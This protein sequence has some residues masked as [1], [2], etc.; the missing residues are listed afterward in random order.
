MTSPRLFFDYRGSIFE[1]SSP[2]VVDTPLEC[3]KKQG[4]KTRSCFLTRFMR[5]CPRIVYPLPFI[6]NHNF[7]RYGTKGCV[8]KA[9]RAFP[10]HLQGRLKTETVNLSLKNAIL[11]LKLTGLFHFDILFVGCF[12]SCR[13]QPSIF[14]KKQIMQFTAQPNISKMLD[15][16]QYNF[17]AFLI[18]L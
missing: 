11:C 10:S 1:A 7:A 3:R 13:G 2:S 17:D 8:F 15:N 9:F 16:N 18:Y 5:R 12:S 4:L 14:H 6:R